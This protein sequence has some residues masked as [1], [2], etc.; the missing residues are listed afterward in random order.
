MDEAVKSFSKDSRLAT[1]DS[2]IV[3]IMSHGVKGAIL[4]VHH[5]IGVPDQFPT[6]NIYKHLESA[7]CKQLE[8]KPKVIII[9]ACRGGVLQVPFSI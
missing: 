4:G 6:D 2:V 7:N 3:V 9:Q 1:T 8:G 5:C